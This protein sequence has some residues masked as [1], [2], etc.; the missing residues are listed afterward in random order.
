MAKAA[1]EARKSTVFGSPAQPA[2]ADASPVSGLRKSA[3]RA[4]AS[5]AAAA[6]VSGEPGAVA[7]HL[8]ADASLYLNEAMRAGPAE[9]LF[10]G[11]DEDVPSLVAIICQALLA[12][13]LNE[14]RALASN[15]VVV[16]GLSCLSGFM[17]RLAQE[18]ADAMSPTGHFPTL[19]GLKSSV[20]LTN[21]TSSR[22]IAVWTGGSVL[23]QV[24]GVADGA[25]T[26]QAWSNHGVDVLP[27]AET[28][29]LGPDLER[30]SV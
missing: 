12:A 4:A 11:D 10:D 15:L 27:Q 25:I 22:A 5:A 29:A 24:P 8:G 17:E 20:S 23:A 3:S 21:M 26:K 1:T 7:Y 16:G 6:A 14:R 9:T 2:A 30:L 18:L 28:F 19:A 13:P